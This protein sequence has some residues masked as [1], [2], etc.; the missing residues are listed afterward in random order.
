[1][2]ELEDVLS[3]YDNPATKGFA[4]H[5]VGGCIRELPEEKI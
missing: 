2:K 1:M 5:D 3:N 4:Y